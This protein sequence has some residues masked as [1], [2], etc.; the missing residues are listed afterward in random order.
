[1]GLLD[2]PNISSWSCMNIYQQAIDHIIVVSFIANSN[3][4]MKDDGVIWQ[5]YVY[6]IS[7]K[8]WMLL[9]LS[10]LALSTPILPFLVTLIRNMT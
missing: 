3:I 7:K 5:N 1:M 2:K 10:S 4:F 6:E 9:T 8:A